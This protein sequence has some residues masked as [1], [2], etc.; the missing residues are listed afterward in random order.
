MRD[1]IC[2]LINRKEKLNEIEITILRM[3]AKC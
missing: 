1:D 2:D 3:I